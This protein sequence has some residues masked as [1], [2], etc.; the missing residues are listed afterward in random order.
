MVSAIIL[1][2]Y[3][4]RVYRSL[5]GFGREF[6]V[7]ASKHD[8]VRGA[9]QTSKFRRPINIYVK[10]NIVEVLFWV[11]LG[12]FIEWDTFLWSKSNSRDTLLGFVGMGTLLQ[13]SVVH[14]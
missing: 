13:I 1:P 4:Y 14:E 7:R 8:G 10:H 9:C 12:R 2:Q 11:M 3:T 6:G 5:V